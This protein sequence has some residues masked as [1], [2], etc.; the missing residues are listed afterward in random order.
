MR[1]NAAQRD[2]KRYA[3]MLRSA[4]CWLVAALLVAAYA[5]M[6]GRY[7][8]NFPSA[9]DF[10]TI[11]RVPVE[12]AR[13]LTLREKLTKL[14]EL[15]EAHRFVTLRLATLIEAKVLGTID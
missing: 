11:L 13:A 4:A 10:G 6:V 3:D 9:D 12:W 7:A 1:L 8:V 14:T 2:R 15:V 5:A